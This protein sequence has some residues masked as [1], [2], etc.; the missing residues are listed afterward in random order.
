MIIEETVTCYEGDR[1]HRHDW[2][3]GCGKCP[4]CELRA[5]G[6]ARYRGR[7]ASVLGGAAK[8]KS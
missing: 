8:E 5:A 3:Y 4:A 7:P 1:T 6:Y 2:G